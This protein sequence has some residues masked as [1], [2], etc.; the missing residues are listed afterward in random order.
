M[1]GRSVVSEV[2][3]LGGAAQVVGS[4]ETI[5]IRLSLKYKTITHL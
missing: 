3:G 4:L 1:K 5:F 2:F